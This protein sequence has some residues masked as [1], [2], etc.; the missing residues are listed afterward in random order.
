M[1]ILWYV[2]F[3]YR[4]PLKSPQIFRFEVKLHQQV[5]K[6]QN[7]GVERNEEPWLP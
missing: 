1:F 6:V 5:S 4:I 7:Q 3:Q 2:A